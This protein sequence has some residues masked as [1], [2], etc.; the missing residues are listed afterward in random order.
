[1]KLTVDLDQEPAL[2][3]YNITTGVVYPLVEFR[4]VA[5][6][7]EKEDKAAEPEKTE[8]EKAESE[9]AESEKAAEEDVQLKP[10][11]PE[12]KLV[13]ENNDEDTDDDLYC[14]YSSIDIT[15]LGIKLGAPA[16][17]QTILDAE[18][19]VLDLLDRQGYPFAR[20]VKRDVVAD[21]KAKN[22]K[23]TLTMYSG[24][25][26]YFGETEIKGLKT[27]R[28]SFV[29][30][31][32]AWQAGEP[33]DPQALKDTFTALDNSRLFLNIQLTPE[34]CVKGDHLVPITLDLGESRH[35]SIGFGASYQTQQG[36]GVIAEWEH[37]NIRGV[38]ERVEAKADLLWWLQSGSVTYTIPDFIQDCQELTSRADVWHE[39]TEGFHDTSASVSSRLTR[40]VNKSAVASGG[41][42]LKY[43]T[44]SDSD[45]NNNFVL[46]KV[47][48]QLV[49]ND[50]GCPLDPKKGYSLNFKFT[51]TFQVIND[52]LN[53]YI[54]NLDAA[55]YQPLNK[56]ER[57]VVATKLSLGSVMGASRFDV[58]PPERLY[59][60]SPHLL[61]GYRYMTVSPLDENNKPIGGRSLAVMAFELRQRIGE[62]WGAVLFYE[63]G[64]VYAAT[65]PNFGMKQLQSTGLGARYYTPVGPLSVDIAFPLNRRP[66]IDGPFQF[67]FN[68]GQTF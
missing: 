23:V 39:V 16:Y 67:Y 2:V 61:R 57:T 25:R 24:P 50:T 46:A 62:D 47:P 4:V 56:S 48:L 27:V 44:S 34:D 13:E 19:A 40:R 7:P 29:R 41:G 11:A 51:P 15:T 20:V 53:Y 66:K 36:G 54:A 3:R 49:Y 10:V 60:G 1:M 33:Y 65:V 31:K 17:P 68:I 5:G 22:V 8:S 37:R 14:D 28:E 26:A 6:V 35:R 12:L 64:N 43:L 18:D 58:P 32:I 45:N 63:I 30:R 21:Q 38:G 55:A 9:K 42:A 52:Q 59:A